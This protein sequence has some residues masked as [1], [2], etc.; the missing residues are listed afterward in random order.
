MFSYFFTVFKVVFIIF[1]LLATSIGN[2][3]FF[4]HFT[5]FTPNCHALLNYI[6]SQLLLY[7]YEFIIQYLVLNSLTCNYYA[8]NFYLFK[9]CYTISL[10]AQHLNCI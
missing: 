4:A 7:G 3:C 8:H 5:F 6:S 9:S 2:L 10:L 1:A